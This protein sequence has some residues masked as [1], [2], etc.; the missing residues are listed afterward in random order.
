MKL[1]DLHNPARFDWL[2]DQGFRLDSSPYLSGAYEARKLLERLPGTMP[3]Q[4][5]TTGHDGGI[6]NGPKFSRLY[7]TD[8]DWGVPFLGSTDML[9]ADFTNVPL[10]H[11]KVAGHFPY[12]KVEPGMTMITCSGTIGRTT[13]VRQTWPDSGRPSIR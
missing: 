12:L 9:E 2:A 4:R 8:P 10:L 3:L 1:A 5:V 13:Y 11:K 6:F 7:T